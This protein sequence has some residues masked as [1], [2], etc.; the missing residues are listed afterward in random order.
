M[1]K[2]KNPWADVAIP[3][4]I[5]SL[6]DE[7]NKYIESRGGVGDSKG[8]K[9]KNYDALENNWKIN[10]RGR[11]MDAYLLKY[12][13]SDLYVSFGVRFS[14]EDSDYFSMGIPV[15]YADRVKRLEEPTSAA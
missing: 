13:P 6:A 1:L 3:V 15:E 2:W 9:I 12:R 8:N 5:R 14:D 11:H 10:A 7:Y 4:D